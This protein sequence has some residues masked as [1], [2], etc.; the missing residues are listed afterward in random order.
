MDSLPRAELHIFYLVPGDIRDGAL[1]AAYDALLLPDERAR[2]DRYLQPASKTEYLFTRALVKT[3]LSRYAPV[4][5]GAWRFVA[6][7]FGC[8]EVALPDWRFL[9]FNL[10]NTRDL[11]ACA[12]ACDR[13]VGIDVENR[14]RG[15]QTV[16][17]ADRFFS[18]LEAAAL[19]RLPNDQKRERFF[20]YW[21]LKE[22]YIKARGMGLAIPLDQF[23]FLLDEG[24]AIRVVFAPELGDDAG[25][26]QFAR[27]SLSPDHDTAIAVRRATD[28]DLRIRV[29]RVVPLVD[30][31]G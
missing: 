26:W 8:P 18:P 9:R 14:V 23:S 19:R 7:S 20:A 11:I 30:V 2:R 4:D 6:N 22:A 25:E 24:P 1:L 13:D 10:S 27:L 28:P 17:I 5:P 29:R 21:T 12:V 3:V 31:A 15:G 16:E